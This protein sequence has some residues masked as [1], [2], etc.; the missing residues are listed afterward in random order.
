MICLV[1]YLTCLHA[2]IGLSEIIPR[3][4]LFKEPREDPKNDRYAKPFSSICL[5]CHSPGRRTEAVNYYGVSHDIGK[6]P[7]ES[8]RCVEGGWASEQI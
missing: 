8:A 1:S 6:M 4:A 7:P 5:L 3:C 2:G